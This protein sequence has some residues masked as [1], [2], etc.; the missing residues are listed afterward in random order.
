MDPTP[1]KAEIAL[2]CDAAEV[3]VQGLPWSIRLRR[4]PEEGVVAVAADHGL[5]TLTRQPFM[6]LKPADDRVAQESARESASVRPLR[7]DE[8]EVF[9][10]VLG[11]AFGAPPAIITSLYTRLVL[12]RPFV[13]A[14][15][16]RRG[17]CAR[18]GGLAILTG[19]HVGLVFLSPSGRA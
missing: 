9:A 13:R 12:S 1:D 4:E 17:Q 10:D 2:L 7:K 18:R 8:H 6:L 14:Y 16:V 15:V 3:H 19:E 11:S 5:T